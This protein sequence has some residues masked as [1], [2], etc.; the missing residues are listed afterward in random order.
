ML[1]VGRLPKTDDMTVIADVVASA[2]VFIAFCVL[3]FVFAVF[4][5]EQAAL[6]EI[7]PKGMECTAFGERWAHLRRPHYVPLKAAL[8]CD[9]LF[10][11]LTCCIAA[12][13]TRTR[14]TDRELKRALEVAFHES[15]TMF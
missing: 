5:S 10:S 6:V 4:L 9:C 13:P 2:N 11:N 15:G 14:I 12:E 7:Q 1:T 8:K 3:S